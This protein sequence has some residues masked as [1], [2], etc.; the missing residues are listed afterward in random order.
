MKPIL[1]LLT[2]ALLAVGATACGAGTVKAPASPVSSEARPPGGTTTAPASIASSGGYLKNDGD[3]DFDDPEHGRGRGDPEYDASIL[4]A[5]FGPRADPA[6]ARAVTTLVK[7]YYAASAAEN[8]AKACSLLSA[9]L[10]IGVGG[11]PGGSAGSVG[12]GCA[13]SMSSLLKQQHQLLLQ[14]EVATMVVTSVH[15][16]HNLGV[17]ALG[18]RRM[19]ESEILVER[20]GRTWKIDALFGGDMP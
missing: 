5:P 1:A 17:A 8:G 18:F 7:S 3:K 10:T 6:D 11:D 2:T 4:F 14:E 19:P 12:N 9:G 13:S 20:E 15:V 16:K